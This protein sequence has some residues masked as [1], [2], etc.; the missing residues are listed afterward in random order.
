MTEAAPKRSSGSYF[1]DSQDLL[2]SVVLVLPLFVAYQIGVL[3]TGGI[4][5][6]VDFMTS[7][8]LMLVG[9]SLAGY[10]AVNVGVLLALLTVVAIS[11]RRRRTANSRSSS[12]LR[13]D[14]EPVYP[15]RSRAGRLR[16]T[17]D[18]FQRKTRR[19]TEAA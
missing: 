3:T 17:E 15:T 6:G 11:R 13:I 8:L 7:A 16:P 18:R 19:S 14:C 10:L 2:T 4:R 12:D 5:N 1:T 9:N